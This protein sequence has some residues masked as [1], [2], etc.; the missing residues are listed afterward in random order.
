MQFVS[1]TLCCPPAS[2][3][4]RRL[5]QSAFF[6][7]FTYL[8]FAC[9]SLLLVI[10]MYAPSAHLGDDHLYGVDAHIVISG[11]SIAIW[12]HKK[13]IVGI[14]ICLWVTN[15]AFLLQGKFLPF[16]RQLGIPS[17]HVWQE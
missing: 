16:Y 10:R 5:V 13:A 6:Q 1:T 11:A 15:I 2:S 14:A 9:A 8:A 12:N 4:R 17:K 3:K 7:A